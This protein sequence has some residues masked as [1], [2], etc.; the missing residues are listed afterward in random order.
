MT[1]QY[2]EQDAGL[3]DST[4]SHGSVARERVSGA[5]ELAG[6]IRTP[7][8]VHR[9]ASRE[10]L[11]NRLPAQILT[12]PDTLRSELCDVLR[13]QREGHR[14]HSQLCTAIIPVDQQVSASRCAV[15]LQS[16][17]SQP[18]AAPIRPCFHPSGRRW[19]SSRDMRDSGNTSKMS[20]RARGEIRTDFRC[21][22]LSE[23]MAGQLS[24][25]K[26]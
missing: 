14:R 24:G 21:L 19:A 8:A 18:Q 12:R 22:A 15:A 11:L 9:S 6:M 4:R 20:S 16:E 26:F 3:A 7:S 13:L 1:G 5:R 23:R 25:G 17:T 2:Q 10:V